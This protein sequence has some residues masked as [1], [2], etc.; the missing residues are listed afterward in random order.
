TM[1]TPTE[2]TGENTFSGSQNG[3]P[4]SSPRIV[5]RAVSHET[6]D[7][8]AQQQQY[9]SHYRSSRATDSQGNESGNLSRDGSMDRSYTDQSG[10]LAS[11]EYQTGDKMESGVSRQTSREEP[12]KTPEPSPGPPGGN[13]G[14]SSPGNKD[15]VERKVSQTSKGDKKNKKAWYNFS[16]TYKSRSEDLKR[17]FK[18]LPGDERLIVDYSCAL[19]KD[20]LVHGR[21]YVTPNYFCFY[22]KIFGWE[23]F[24]SI[25]CKE[26]VSMTK[27]KTALVIPNA[28]QINSDSDKNFFTSFA[29]RDKTYLMLFRIWQNA[30]MDQSVPVPPTV[31]K[32]L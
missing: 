21:L 29:S 2:A 7:T 24:M 32:I 1:P 26:I 14:L 9:S 4:H 28:I 22:S 19:Q 20:I 17:L 12:P 3:S 18:K 8:D 15:H 5:R 6:S 10:Y 27:E 23:T 11:M 13:T 25:R 30:L 16:S 31:A